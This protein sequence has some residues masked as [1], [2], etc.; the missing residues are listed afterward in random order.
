MQGELEYRADFLGEG[1]WHANRQTM[2]VPYQLLLVLLQAN[3]AVGAS[4]SGCICSANTNVCTDGKCM[5]LCPEGGRCDKNCRCPSSTP[6]CSA[7]KCKVRQEWYVND[8]T[9]LG[10]GYTLE[11]KA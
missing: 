4:C 7:G 8:P 9:N 10:R 5:R 11:Q 2:L 6:L 3:C 1:G